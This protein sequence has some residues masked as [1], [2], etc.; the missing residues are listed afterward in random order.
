MAKTIRAFFRAF[1][2]AH[3]ETAGKTWWFG[4]LGFVV[5]GVI[6]YAMRPPAQFPWLAIGVGVLGALVCW[7]LCIFWN[8]AIVIPTR[9][10][11]KATETDKY[12]AALL[13]IDGEDVLAGLRW[14]YLLD[15]GEAP[16]QG[17]LPRKW[18]RDQ[19]FSIGKNPD[20]YN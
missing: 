1:A 9:L 12:I 14:K 15:K 20:E 17:I 13:K 18:M 10:Q 5:T 2:M 6:Y 8:M 4:T 19:L 3:A 11:A 7:L 16:P